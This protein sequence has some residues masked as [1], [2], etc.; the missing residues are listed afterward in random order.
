MHRNAEIVLVHDRSRLSIVVL[1]VAYRMS[2]KNKTKINAK[3]CEQAVG[4]MPCNIIRPLIIRL[5]WN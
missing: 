3:A 5:F 4:I 2:K 1:P